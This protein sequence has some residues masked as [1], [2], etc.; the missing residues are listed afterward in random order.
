MSQQ[1]MFGLFNPESG[2]AVGNAII[3]PLRAHPSDDNQE[4]T[5]F[6]SN[7]NYSDTLNSPNY[8]NESHIKFHLP[9]N[10]Q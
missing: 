8:G 1:Q 9:A 10:I 4:G 3:N 2:S 6:L 5:F 7:H